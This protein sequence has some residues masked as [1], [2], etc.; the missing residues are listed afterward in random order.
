MFPLNS[1]TLYIGYSSSVLT[2][3][4]TYGMFVPKNTKVITR[5]ISGL[6]YDVRFFELF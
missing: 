6:T 3:P 1:N 5:N 4:D 2:D